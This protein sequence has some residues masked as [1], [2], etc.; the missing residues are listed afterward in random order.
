MLANFS[1]I[2]FINRGAG[3]LQGLGRGMLLGLSL[4]VIGGLSAGDDPPGFLNLSAGDKA[5]LYGSVWGFLGGVIGTPTGA[6]SGEKD[7]F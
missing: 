1:N 5:A 7:V 4:G 6:I 3:A 2:K